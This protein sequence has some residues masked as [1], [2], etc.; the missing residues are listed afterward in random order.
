MF[1]DVGKL[2]KLINGTNV[3]WNLIKPLGKRNQSL[4]N[5]LSEK[6]KIGKLRDNDNRSN[7]IK[8]DKKI[9]LDF[10]LGSY[11]VDRYKSIS[12]IVKIFALKLVELC[13]T[14]SLQKSLYVTYKF[15]LLV[16]DYEYDHTIF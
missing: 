4:H 13:L 7:L 9:I 12:M 8:R 16:P 5:K 10:I 6:H 11:T 2:N 14:D 3:S 1:V 15:R